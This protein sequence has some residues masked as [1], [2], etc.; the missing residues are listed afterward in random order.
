MD[1]DTTLFLQEVEKIG[2]LQTVEEQERVVDP[3][4]WLRA[5]VC[6]HLIREQRMFARL[7]GFPRSTKSVYVPRDVLIAAN[8]KTLLRMNHPIQVKV[9]LNPDQKQSTFLALK[10]KD[11]VVPRKGNKE[12]K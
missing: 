4:E 10:I 6:Y 12:Q 1:S 3:D 9:Q 8:F 7:V 2:E 11:V 5:K